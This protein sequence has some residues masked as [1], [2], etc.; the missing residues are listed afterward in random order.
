MLTILLVN[1]DGYQSEG[2]GVLE[3]KLA[4][5]G[6][7]IWTMAPSGN[8]SA[9]SHA[10]NIR[11]DAVITRY[12]D[13]HYHCS[14]TPTDCILYALKSNIFPSKPDLVVSGI[15]HGYNCSTDI[16]YSGTC[17]AASEAVIHG[18]PAVALSADVDENGKYD[19][20]SAATWASDNIE[21]LYTLA[22]REG[23]FVNVNFPNPFSGKV[24]PSSLGYIIYPDTIHEKDNDGTC[25]V[26]SL[27]SQDVRRIRGEGEEAD[28]H[29]TRNGDIAVSVIRVLP[30]IDPEGQRMVSELFCR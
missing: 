27:A 9:Q 24:K 4:S 14:G 5:K 10:M 2:I 28:F 13:E 6:F 17:G 26:F 20:A 18:I 21:K 7:R 19:F 15:N 30:E 8:R 16:L 11:E 25:R 29:V 1:D 12:G 22:S 23:C 3:K